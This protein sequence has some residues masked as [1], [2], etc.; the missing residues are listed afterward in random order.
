MGWKSLRGAM[1]LNKYDNHV[2]F[3][4][5]VACAETAYFSGVHFVWSVYLVKY[6]KHISSWSSSLQSRQFHEP[7]NFF[8]GRSILVQ[9]H[10]QKSLYSRLETYICGNWTHCLHLKKLHHIV[11]LWH[12]FSADQEGNILSLLTWMPF[13]QLVLECSCVLCFWLFICCLCICLKFFTSS[14]LWFEMF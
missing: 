14:L 13:L 9:W 12:F 8:L 4:S 5:L 11:L 3:S 1:I 10:Q 6:V 7:S 2:C